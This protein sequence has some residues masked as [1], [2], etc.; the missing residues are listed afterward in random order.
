MFSGVEN[1][2]SLHVLLA[3]GREIFFFSV[4]LCKYRVCF[5][6]EKKQQKNTV[7]KKDFRFLLFS[8]NFGAKEKKKKKT[9]CNE[10]GFY[11]FRKF[12]GKRNKKKKKFV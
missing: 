2:L 4:A 1:S 8:V 7:M 6:K 12:W 5:K 9:H 10:K 11:F 3:R